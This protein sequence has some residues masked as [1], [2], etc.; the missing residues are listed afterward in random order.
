MPS[1]EFH[2]QPVEFCTLDQAL[3]AMPEPAPQAPA[4]G[5]S[6]HA[7]VGEWTVRNLRTQDALTCA[8]YA[9]AVA[10]LLGTRF[11]R[12]EECFELQS[13]GRVLDVADRPH[14]R[15]QARL[16]NPNWKTLEEDELAWRDDLRLRENQARL[17]ALATVPAIGGF[18]H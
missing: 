15:L 16:E 14:P 1:L 2:L 12:P 4:Q 6:V 8:D 17:N 11:L 13:M 9:L 18:G 3:A 5:Y 10:Y 7:P